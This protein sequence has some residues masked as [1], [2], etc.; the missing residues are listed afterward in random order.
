MNANLTAKQTEALALVADNAG[1]V[2]FEQRGIQGVL[3]INGNTERALAKKGLIRKSDKVMGTTVSG[4]EYYAWEITA[5]GLAA[6]GREVEVEVT[7]TVEVVAEVVATETA[8]VE[9]T[10]AAAYVIEVRYTEGGEWT[11]LAHYT[12]RGEALREMDW[13]LERA[14]G[15]QV[16]RLRALD[17]A[18]AAEAEVVRT[19]RRAARR[20][21]VAAP[22]RASRSQYPAVRSRLRLG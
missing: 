8:E 21:A 20:K 11:E 10:E 4:F 22:R 9:V 1:Q 16:Y 6:L 13:V 5:E 19:E 7:E 17:G 15:R 14:I 18:Q 3:T 2:V 12:D